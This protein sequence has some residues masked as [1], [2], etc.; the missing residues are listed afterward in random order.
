ME[1][2]NDKIGQVFLDLAPYLKFYSTYANDFK[3][4]TN[5]VEEQLAKN[6][7]FRL[8]M[9]RQESRPE[10]CKKLN[11]LLITP[12]QRIPRY[13]LLLDDIIK[14]TPRY[15][16]DKVQMGEKSIKP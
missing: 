1:I 7:P 8:F 2:S 6:K 9:E 10:V 12:V 13:K 16:P 15:H 5:L 14:N 3:Q 4:A 11:A